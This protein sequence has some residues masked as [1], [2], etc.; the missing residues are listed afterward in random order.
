MR[1]DIILKLQRIIEGNDHI[2]RDLF[3]AIYDGFLEVD[4]LSQAEDKML[5][6][7]AS[8]IQRCSD[9]KIISTATEEKTAEYEMEFGLLS[10]GLTLEQRRQQ[11]IDYINRSRVF[12]ESTLHT[13]CQSMAGDNAVY[14][15]TDT[16]ALTLGIF[17]EE[18]E[19]GTLPAPGIVNNIRPIVPQNLSLYSGVDSSFTRPMIVNR[20]HMA[21]IKTNMGIV[22]RH[23]PV[24]HMIVVNEQGRIVGG[25]ASETEFGTVG[26]IT[27][28]DASET[29]FG[30]VGQITIEDGEVVLV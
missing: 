6:F 17:T 18:N 28:E 9:D 23:D 20:A 19:D 12:N 22:E 24:F 16:Q 25:D 26:Q 2:T 30:T 15:R 4:E 1:D 29:E 11:V 7:I 13:L 14:E 10:D 21:A 8:T 5:Q 3:P 27:I